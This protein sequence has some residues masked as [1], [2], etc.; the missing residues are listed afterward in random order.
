MIGGRRWRVTLARP[1]LWALLGSAVALALVGVYA[2][3]VAS[4]GKASGLSPLAVRQSVYLAA[5]LAMAV[6]VAAPDYRRAGPLVW[7]LYA[8]A[9]A[10]LVFLLLPM[11]P[12]SI[13][14]P[15]N[16]ARCWIDLGVMNFQPG[17]FAK[18]ACILAI[19]HYLRHRT[20]HRRFLGFVPPAM[21][22]LAPMALIV[23]QPDL[24]MATLFVPTLFAMLV[25]AG[26]RLKHIALVVALGLAS[27][28]AAYPFLLPHQKAR[29]DALLKQAQGDHSGK[30]SS[31][32][33]QIKAVTLA[34]AGGVSGLGDRRS[35]TV[36]DFND[37][38][39]AH[40]DMI[41]AVIVNRFGLV[42][43]LAVIG[44]LLTWLTSAV[45]IAAR[46]KDP[47][48]RLIAVGLMAMLAAQAAVN[49]GMCLGVAPIVGITLPFVSAGGSSM[50]ACFA[51]T[52]LLANIAIRPP[53][54]LE[55]E[56]FDFEGG[57]RE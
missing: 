4:G 37:L 45:V 28:P 22:A 52:G 57:V 51:A 15:I 32:Y 8:V 49:I 3:D 11:V 20:T 14:R 19:A 53:K 17:E 7:P 44:L 21:I 39:E 25:A 46:T 35:R 26:A 54:R 40:N 43:G 27:A 50:L 10:L 12:R 5:G 41:Y 13:V 2:I 30:E 24:G 38:P 29:I 34:G 47:F 48:G 9:V 18:I 6:C 36:L 31:Q 55:R 23:V 1:E 33:Q 56:P 42:G 16:G